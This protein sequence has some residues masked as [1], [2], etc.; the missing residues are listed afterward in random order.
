MLWNRTR[1]A[2][3]LGRDSGQRAEPGSVGR[4]RLVRRQSLGDYARQVRKD[5]GAKS[6]PKVF[7]N[8]NLPREDKLSVV[9]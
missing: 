8:D 7:D 4:T 3:R 9:G 1:A 6:K 5:P 2:S